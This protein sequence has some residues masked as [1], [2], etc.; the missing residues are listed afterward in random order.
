[1]SPPPRTAGKLVVRSSTCRSG[2]TAASFLR[3]SISLSTRREPTERRR[4]PIGSLADLSTCP[5]RL[6]RQSAR[7]DKIGGPR[8][9]SSVG[10]RLLHTQEV[11]GS[12]PPPPTNPLPG[13]RFRSCR[14][15]VVTV[16][17]GRRRAA[18]TSR[19]EAI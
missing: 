5:P 11:G 1:M 15:R 4:T 18:G 16:L 17:E 7:L 8:A 13:C 6:D 9:A 10:E 2:C 19:E 12:K 14:N 3:T